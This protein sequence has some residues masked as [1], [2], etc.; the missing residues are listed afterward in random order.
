MK[1]FEYKLDKHTAEALGSTLDAALY[2][3]L[4]FSA[5]FEYEGEYIGCM[6]IMQ[7]INRTREKVFKILTGEEDKLTINDEEGIVCLKEVLDFI[8]D[9]DDN[10]I[11]DPID[12]GETLN[13]VLYHADEVQKTGVKALYKAVL[14]HI[15]DN[16]V[17]EEIFEFDTE[18]T[19]K[20]YYNII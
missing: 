3:Q 8:K 19:F 15:A 13:G 9:W 14:K 4:E 6:E 16:Y 12:L 5:D 10:S 2:W 11:E 17:N 7:Y 1:I 18:A 20:D